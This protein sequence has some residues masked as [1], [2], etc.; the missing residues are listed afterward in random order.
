ML[1]NVGGD[2]AAL[3]KLGLSILPNSTFSPLQDS[4]PDD[5]P[6]IEYLVLDAYFSSGSDSSS[7]INDGKQYAAASVGLVATFSQSNVLI[8]S[9]EAAVNPIISPNRL[10]DPRDLD[11]AIAAFRRGRDL[12]ATNAMKPVVGTEEFPGT[13]LTTREQILEIVRAS[14]NSI[15]NA[16]GTCKTGKPDDPMAVVSS[17]GKVFGVENLRVVDACAFPFLPP[18]Q[19][20]ATVCKSPSKRLCLSRL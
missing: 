17:T 19:P 3:E 4:F 10:T 5:W 2:V 13:D 20:S 8:A 14:A 18:G 16:A 6:H 15:Y 11:M 12:F 7:G 1:T 9:P